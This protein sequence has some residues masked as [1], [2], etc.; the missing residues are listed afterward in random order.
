MIFSD[1]FFGVLQKLTES[2]VSNAASHVPNAAAAAGVSQETQPPVN[3]DETISFS[4][5]EMDAPALDWQPDDS[6]LFP[7]FGVDRAREL[8]MWLINLELR[9]PPY[10]EVSA[11]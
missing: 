1:G 2:F 11:A 10:S 6:A 7:N 4:P 9:L 8:L 5:E 3:A